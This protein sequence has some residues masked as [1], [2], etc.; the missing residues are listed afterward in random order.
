MPAKAK[1]KKSKTPGLAETKTE[2]RVF[3]DGSTYVGECIDHNG[4]P[5]RHGTGKNT[6]ADGSSYEGT[7]VEDRMSGEGTSGGVVLKIDTCVSITSCLCA[8]S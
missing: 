3:A 1:G 2:D 4:A 8:S 7:F 6:F 5:L